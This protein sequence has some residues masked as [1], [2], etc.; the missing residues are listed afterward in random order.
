MQS[1]R[2]YAL[3][4]SAVMAASVLSG[5][6]WW[7]QEDEEGGSGSSS[8]ESTG[9][10][11][12]GIILPGWP[13]DDGDDDKTPTLRGIAITTPPAKTEYQINETF[14][15][16][17][18]VVTAYYSN[19]TSRPVT[20][21]TISFSPA[22]SE[23]RF[24]QTGNYIM[25]VTYEGLS[26]LLTI[27]VSPD[28]TDPNT[29]TITANGTLIVPKDAKSSQINRKLFDTI[30]KDFNSIDLTGSGI[31]SIEADAFNYLADWDINGEQLTSINLGEVSTIGERAFKCCIGLQTV[32]LGD[33]VTEIPAAAFQMC[34]NL[35]T[36][37]LGHVI[38]IGNRAFMDCDNL[39]NIDLHNVNEI[40]ELGFSS[41]FR[42]ASIDLSN[43][44][45]IGLAA[46]EY[47]IDLSNIRIGS[48]L[49]SVGKAAFVQIETHNVT[50]FY[51]DG[52]DTDREKLNSIL[53][54]S[55]IGSESFGSPLGNYELCPYDQY[56]NG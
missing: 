22:L 26:D 20:D 30:T 5:C 40:G 50:V 8:S 49:S 39:N 19:G 14:N 36:I 47:N 13:D 42:L 28:P 54:N 52:T 4:L 17:G 12:G 7:M 27:A 33:N 21:Y 51:G 56:P 38:K 23:G 10:Q 6:E 53:A 45:T 11:G 35:T 41:C 18:M 2:F 3:A 15:S 1:K 9:G 34:T 29:W 37:N 44:K 25:T 46:F 16:A 24:T 43:I 55:Y 32:T 48:S 31:T